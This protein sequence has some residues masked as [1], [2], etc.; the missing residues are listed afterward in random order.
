M[1]DAMFKSGIKGAYNIA[2]SSFLT[3]GW[4]V[5]QARH[6]QTGRK[7]SVFIFDKATFESQLTRLNSHSSGIGDMKLIVEDTYRLLKVEI[8]QLTK[9]K[10]PQ[11]LSVIEPYEETKLKILFVTEP[12]CAT[13]LNFSIPSEERFLAVKGLYEIGKGLLFLHNTCNIVHHNLQPDSIFISDEGGWKL[14]GFKFLEAIN[15]LSAN[16]RVGNSWVNT[17]SNI[18]FNN[19]NL[20]FTAPEL[21]LDGLARRLT[22][23][24]DMWSMGTII[25]WL[26]NNGE[27][28]INCLDT[29]SIPDYRAEYRI[30]ERKLL[31]A[32][33]LSL[34]HIFKSVPQAQ[35]TDLLL[36]LKRTP[37]ERMKISDFLMLSLFKGGFIEIMLDLDEFSSKLINEKIAL[38]NE[39]LNDKTSSHKLPSSFLTTKLIPNL[40]NTIIGE[41]KVNSNGIDNVER[42]TLICQALEL[43]LR[44]GDSLSSMS[45]REKIYKPLLDSKSTALS[46]CAFHKLILFSTQV[47]LSIVSNMNVLLAKLPSEDSADI[48]R[49]LSELCLL[50][51]LVSPKDEDDQITLQ[52]LFLSKIHLVAGDFDY[53][54][55]KKSL[56]PLLC[57]VFR[58]TVILSTKIYLVATFNS[59]LKKGIIH[60]DLLYDQIIPVLE[61]LKSRRKEI[62]RSVLSF[63]EGLIF[64]SRIRLSLETLTSKVL[65]HSYRLAFSCADCDRNEFQQLL[66]MI[67][68]LQESLVEKKIGEISR[69]NRQAQVVN[70]TTDAQ[71]SSPNSFN[72]LKSNISLNLKPAQAESERRIFE[73]SRSTANLWK[74]EGELSPSLA[75]SRVESPDASVI[76]ATSSVPSVLRTTRS[77]PPLSLTA[78]S[79]SLRSTFVT[80]QPNNI[81]PVPPGYSF[82]EAL[83][84]KTKR[85]P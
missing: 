38:L 18:P 70:R 20:D 85:T 66:Q 62:I 9:L 44:L 42:T 82:F 53:L 32:N 7:V 16:E 19:L 11:I 34:R 1:F 33:E 26:F 78:N 77:Q 23:S 30:L 4:K 80:L 59:L 69:L 2:D 46:D 21:V 75:L 24:S 76:S 43:V 27:Q 12:I 83:T 36:L 48:V 84:P 40:T 64:Q 60:E 73:N 8:S 25:Y 79:P 6:R 31:E 15:E 54:Y 71:I 13:L 68:R 74:S 41:L 65:C 22:V 67:N 55:M 49:K 58:K 61:N 29:A 3:G 47:R 28:I 5:H 10:H 39:L 51:S 45:F 50:P 57:D 37:S 35:W 72:A 63:Y 14:G 17:T 56:T 52:N 81:T